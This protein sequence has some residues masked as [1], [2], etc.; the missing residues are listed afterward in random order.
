[1][2]G[3]SSDIPP[4]VL[5]L[6]DQL[7]AW[8]KALKEPASMLPTA[9]EIRKTKARLKE[10]GQFNLE[11]AQQFEQRLENSIIL[12][13]IKRYESNVDL[14]LE[15]LQTHPASD[16]GWHAQRDSVQR[17]LDQLAALS[18]VDDATRRESL[19]QI[20]RKLTGEE[21]LHRAQQDA[22]ETTA[23]LLKDEKDEDYSNLVQDAAAL[24]HRMYKVYQEAQSSQAAPEVLEDLAGQYEKCKDFYERNRRAYEGALTADV[25]GEYEDALGILEKVR[26][27]EGPT[28]RVL[29]PPTIDSTEKDARLIPAAKAIEIC[30]M[31]W[32]NA[33]RR[34]AEP[35]IDE[36]E[37]LL[38]EGDPVKADAKLKGIVGEERLPDSDRN[39]IAHLRGRVQSEL[40]EFGRFE[41]AIRECL[42]LSPRLLG[43]RRLDEIGERYERFQASSHV[44]Q[45]NREALREYVTGEIII[46]LGEAASMIS[47]HDLE[48]SRKLTEQVINDLRSWPSDF[49]EPLRY[50]E[51]LLHLTGE[52]DEMLPKAN[53]ELRSR[54]LDAAATTLFGVSDS[55]RQ[56]RQQLPDALARSLEEQK[57]SRRLHDVLDSYQHADSLLDRLQREVRET[58]ETAELSRLTKEIAA[59][60]DRVAAEYKADFQELL[61]YA[62]ARYSYFVGRGILI[63]AGDPEEAKRFLTEAA[64]HPDFRMEA[65]AEI[66]DIDKRLIPANQAV[67]GA[68]RKMEQAV[69]LGQFWEAYREGIGVTSQPAQKSLR[70]ELRRQTGINRA[71]AVTESTERLKDAIASGTGDPG[72]LREHAGRLGVLDPETMREIAVDLWPLVFSLEAEAAIRQGEWEKAHTRYTDALKAVEKPPDSRHRGR[73]TTFRICAEASKKQH[74]L[75]LATRLKPALAVEVLQQHLISQYAQ[76]PDLSLAVARALKERAQGVEE[77]EGYEPEDLRGDQVSLLRAVREDLLE[78]RRSVSSAEDQAQWWLLADRRPSYEQE[79]ARFIRSTPEGLAEQRIVDVGVERRHIQAA[80]RLNGMKLGI[81]RLLPRIGALRTWGAVMAL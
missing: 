4:L 11:Q 37:R 31:R 39:R 52:L 10:L 47:R 13:S 76:D 7:Q 34:R 14:I 36:A 62:T 28:A 81:A 17:M 19:A 1:M 46:A 53:N 59:H 57:E 26:E 3:E 38:E 79:R 18:L 30:M 70:E 16:P 50:A 69:Q 68:L 66:A 40:V 77:L 67:Q 33:L 21:I 71:K 2:S 64:G 22:E 24:M 45:K 6:T 60:L 35:H 51:V 58:E 9:E 12:P 41:Q 75:D 78:A 20:A 49:A 80:L 29:Y 65:N 15:Q 56:V 63:V 73:A 8:E 72:E 23:R 5:E 42:D 48:P 43:W 25:Q 54:Q 27:R 74:I 55:L 61:T 32:G 44:W